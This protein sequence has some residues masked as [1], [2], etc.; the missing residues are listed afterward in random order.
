MVGLLNELPTCFTFRNLL[1]LYYHHDLLGL[2]LCLA[3]DVQEQHLY[4]VTD[5]NV[6]KRR[7]LAEGEASKLGTVSDLG[8][9]PGKVA[10]SQCTIDQ[11]RR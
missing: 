7:A 2:S 9:V 1:C 10:N 5:S 4:W 3:L 11:Q 6:L 8:R